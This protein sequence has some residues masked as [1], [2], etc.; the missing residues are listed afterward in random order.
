MK[1][2]QYRDAEM[3]THTWFWTDDV[4]GACV[5]PYFDSESD[6][7]AWL[8]QVFEGSELVLVDNY[9]R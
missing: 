6:A 5:S 1:L 3:T 8:D 2:I 9:L 7:R 4:T